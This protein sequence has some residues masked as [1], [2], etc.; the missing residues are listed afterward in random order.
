MRDQDSLSRMRRGAQIDSL[1]D[2]DPALAPESGL[3]QMIAADVLS[4]AGE[5][6]VDGSVFHGAFSLRLP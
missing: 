3:L 5:R 4:R 6:A 2:V 1:F